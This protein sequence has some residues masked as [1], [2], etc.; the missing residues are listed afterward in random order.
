VEKSKL[1]AVMK[2]GSMQ[3]APNDRA[4]FWTFG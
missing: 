4:L 2:H 3:Y 1:I